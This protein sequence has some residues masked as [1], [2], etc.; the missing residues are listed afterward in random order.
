MSQKQQRAQLLI[1]W[2]REWV[3]V[4]VSESAQ[5]REAAT[6]DQIEGIGGKTAVLL[7]SRRLVLQ[8][9]ITLPDAQKSDALVALKM[10]LADVFPIPASELAFDFIP[11]SDKNENGRVCNVYAARTSDIAEA[12]ETCQKLGIQIQQIVPAQALTIKLAEQNA[13]SSGIFVERFGDFVNLDAFKYGE[14]VSS[15]LS[16]LDLLDT[17]LARLKAMTG[18]STKVLSYNVS[19]DGTE[20]KLASPHLASY[21]QIAPTIDLE[22]EEF[23]WARIE[24]VRHQHHRQAYMIFAAGFVIAA[25]TV[26]DVMTRNDAYAKEEAKYKNRTKRVKAEADKNI[27]ASTK[28]KPQATQFETAFKPAQQPSDVLKVISGL[29][30]KNTWLTSVVFERGKLLQI[31]GTTQKPQ[32]V[33]AYASSLSEQKRLRDVR[34]VFV[35]SGDIEGTPTVQFNI[36]AF[37]V[38]NL[39]MLETGKKK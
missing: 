28:L 36:T 20:Q 5:L 3:R 11:T 1:E 15:K 34:L 32:L 14:P 37:P 4:Q 8:R 6:L 35:N 2:D 23:R 39:P 9:S 26:N 7:M 17:E 29:I 22:P 21:Y 25:F 30:P 27:T 31:R 13:V 24:K 19:L 10:R 12:I 38:G 16:T 33:S 18:E